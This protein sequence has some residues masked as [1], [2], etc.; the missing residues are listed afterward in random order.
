[1]RPSCFPRVGS[2]VPLLTLAVLISG[3]AGVRAQ[4]TGTVRQTTVVVLPFEFTAPL[5]AQ[6][7]VRPPHRPSMWPPV[8]LRGPISPASYPSEAPSEG[9]DDAIGV[10]IADLLVERL[11]EVPGIRVLERRRLDLVMSEQRLAVVGDSAVRR[12]TTGERVPA[13]ILRARY[14][15]TGSVTRFGTEERRGLGGVGGPFGLGALGFKRPKTQVAL[16][17]R[18]V[19][20][21][22]GEVIASMT[23]TGTSAKGGSI[24]IGGLG[25]GVGGGVALTSSEFRASALGE[26]TERAIEALV[27]EIVTKR[28]RLQ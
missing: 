9:P 17:A 10:G 7:R 26:A 28:D 21:V 22:T 20:A 14:V 12:D 11:L 27:A 18:V 1:M 5:P 2:R 4:S 19:D 6:P 8:L 13:A 15:I 25:G 24:L 3:A 23:G 16:T